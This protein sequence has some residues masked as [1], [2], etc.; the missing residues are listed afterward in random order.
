MQAVQ[1]QWGST[2]VDPSRG[3][4]QLITGNQTSVLTI[5]FQETLDPNSSNSVS[6][7]SSPSNIVNEDPTMN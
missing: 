7:I 1:R 5:T 4:F 3:T 2:P 6:S